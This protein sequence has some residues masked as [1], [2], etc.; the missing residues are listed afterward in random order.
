[1]QA[2]RLAAEPEPEPEPEDVRPPS[3]GTCGTSAR[4]ESPTPRS[5]PPRV[6]PPYPFN[7]GIKP[8]H[9]RELSVAGATGAEGTGPIQRTATAT[10]N[11]P[12]DERGSHLEL[13][14]AHGGEST[15]DGDALDDLPS[16]R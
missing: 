1:M 8:S 5:F 15:T 16:P 11:T 2:P 9:A 3:P 7:R 12:G 4:K 6:P 10:P 13:G 14:G